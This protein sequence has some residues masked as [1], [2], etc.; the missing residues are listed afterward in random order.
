MS[1]RKRAQPSIRLSS[2]AKRVRAGMLPTWHKYGSCN[3]L[4]ERTSHQVAF[5]SGVMAAA[6]FVRR[7]TDNEVLAY[8]VLSLLTGG[9]LE[10]REHAP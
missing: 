6:E 1:E 4:A 7:Y 10:E 8:Q 2:K 5:D 3:D 9:L